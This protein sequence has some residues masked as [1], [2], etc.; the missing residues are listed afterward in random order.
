M[1]TPHGPVMRSATK[2]T[3][4]E[5]GGASE[6]SARGPGLGAGPGGLL[7]STACRQDFSHLFRSSQSPGPVSGRWDKEPSLAWTRAPQA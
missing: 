2:A 5:A 6:G 1:S 3:G 7:G 4:T